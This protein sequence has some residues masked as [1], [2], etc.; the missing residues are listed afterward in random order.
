MEHIIL[1]EKKLAEAKVNEND[2]DILSRIK[3]N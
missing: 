1:P 3:R 2:E